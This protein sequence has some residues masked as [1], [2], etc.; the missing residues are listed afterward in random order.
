MGIIQFLVRSRKLQVICVKKAHNFTHQ[1]DKLRVF[2]LYGIITACGNC[3][4]NCYK[5]I[6]EEIMQKP[7][8]KSVK[9]R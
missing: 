3:I 9:V 6:C 7:L 5:K 4:I 1:P 2:R 8:T